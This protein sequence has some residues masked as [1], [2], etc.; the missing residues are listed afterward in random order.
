VKGLFLAPNM[1]AATWGDMWGPH[2]TWDG[3]VKPQ[4]DVAVALGANAIKT[5]I[6]ML[7]YL[8]GGAEANDA[9]TR[10]RQFQAYCLEHGLMVLWVAAPSDFFGTGAQISSALQSFASVAEDFPNVIEID[11]IN[12]INLWGPALPD[13][14]A[15]ASTLATAVRAVTAIPLTTSIITY[16]V[17]DWRSP[18][19]EALGG[20]V[21]L[22]DFHP[23]YASGDA[24]IADARTFRELTSGRPYLMG[25]CG[26][27][28][29]N[30][31]AAQTARW[32]A[33][34][35]ISS[36]P[37]CYGAVG[38]CIADYESQRRYGIYDENL[39]NQRQQL[40][41]PFSGWPSYS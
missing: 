20:I 22:F 40:V 29:F 18:W 5:G 21:D 33:A 19:V 12:E 39:L 7:P 26:L 35:L 2:W 13:A 10:I 23:Y 28:L 4:V 34:G 16:G 11:V 24:T 1:A 14:T 37:E 38:F 30:G 15:A 6:P 8:R 3:W 27:E 25:E 41:Q 17:P 32:E 9:T 31:A 36:E